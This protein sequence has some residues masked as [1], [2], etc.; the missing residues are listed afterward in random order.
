MPNPCKQ[1]ATAWVSERCHPKPIQIL[2]YIWREIDEYVIRYHAVTPNSLIEWSERTKN[3][4][5]AWEMFRDVTFPGEGRKEVED[6]IIKESQD[7]KLG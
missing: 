3:S 6:R 7:N 1:F 2:V 4:D 5:K